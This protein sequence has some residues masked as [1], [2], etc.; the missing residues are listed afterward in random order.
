MI[1]AIF[2]GIL[3]FTYA[4][5]IIFYAIH[6]K[7]LKSYS[8][9]DKNIEPHVSLTIVIPAR[10]EEKNIEALLQSIIK[11]S[12]PA[13][14]R[15]VIIVDDQSTDNTATIVRKYSNEN[16]LLLQLQDFVINKINA[17]KKKAIEIALTKA[18]GELIITTDADCVAPV[19]WLQTIAQFY[20]E[21]KPALI[22]MPVSFACK[23][24][25]LEIFQSLD[26]MTLQGI[27]GAS[28]QAGAHSMCNG[29]NL[30]YT[31]EAFFAVNGFEGI[32]TIASGDDMLLMHKIARKF[33][34]KIMFL[35]S[36]GVIMKTVPMHT[37]QDFF[38]QRIRWASKAD[39]YE[40]KRIFATLILV[41]LFNA[42]MLFLPF[43]CIFYN[44]LL[45]TGVTLFQ[46]WITLLV[47]KTIVELIF[48]LPVASFFGQRIILWWF[49]L[50][51]PFHI[52]YTVCAGWLGKFGNYNWKGRTVK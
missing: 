25:P 18:T 31:R 47:F 52:L 9:R 12:Y 32:D 1:P 28:V 26:F 4:S 43:L 33:P 14:L 23:N 3:F 27:T 20:A 35:K 5:L 15:Q 44:P 42:A 39:K 41:Y 21:K 22:A 45:I 46:T 17:Y 48:L 13:A 34:G 11:Q 50:A 38:N 49:P 7:K 30:A 8:V 19:L 10:N 36:T 2:T 37:L 51:Q 29:A 16:V 40:D 6:W 24:T